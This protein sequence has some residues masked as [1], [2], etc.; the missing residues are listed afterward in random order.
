MASENENLYKSYKPS[1]VAA[2]AFCVIFIILD[3]AQACRVFRTR[4]WFGLTIIIGGL[5]EI[6]GLAARANSRDHLSDKG[7]FII[8]ILLILLAPILF[9]ASIYMF[10]GRLI[11]ASGYSNLSLIRVQWLSKIFIAGDILCFLVQGSGAGMLVNPK[12]QNTAKTGRNIVLGGLGLQVI[13]F[14]IFILT[15]AVFHFRVV[16]KGLLKTVNPKLQLMLMMVVLYFCSVLIMFR[17]IYRLIE[18]KQGETGYLQSHE[19]PTYA[20]DLV[21]MAIIMILTLVWYN[22]DL[23]NEKSSYQLSF[24]PGSANST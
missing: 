14:I 18:Y 2:I 13:I 5:F 11:Y 9:A 23:K 12:D 21:F 20:L 10:L 1:S 16:S 7:P 4:M 3:L 19:W 24:L 17:N 8:Q 15:A 22:T 6:I